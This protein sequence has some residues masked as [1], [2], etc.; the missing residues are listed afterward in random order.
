MIQHISAVTFAVRDM[1]RSVEFYKKL[2]FELVYGGGD[3]AFSS[4][5]AS[6]VF[7]NLSASPGYEH[8][9]WGRVIF[10]LLT[11]TRSIGC[12]WEPGYSPSL[13]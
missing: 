5:K 1:V 3:A 11:W 7:V 6:E 9:W 2:G 4:L 8:R 12:S 10:R 13:P